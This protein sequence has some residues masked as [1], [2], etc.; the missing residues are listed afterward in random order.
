MVSGSKMSHNLENG[1]MSKK[2]ILG[3]VAIYIYIFMKDII[4]TYYKHGYKTQIPKTTSENRCIN[5]LSNKSTEKNH[6]NNTAS[7]IKI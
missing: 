2:M 7:R 5:Q 3:T 6:N 1:K 4:R